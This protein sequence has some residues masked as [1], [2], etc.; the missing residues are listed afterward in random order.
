MPTNASDQERSIGQIVRDL[1]QDFSSLFRSEVALLKLEI[2]DL[3]AKLG[4][5]TALFAGALFC[6]FFGLG[7]LLVTLMLALV[8]LG[9]PAWL[10]ALILTLLLFG[11]AAVLAF[12]GRKKYM[13]IQFIPTQSVATIKGDIESIKSDID[14]V[15]SR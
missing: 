3:A 2:R 11:G 13:A 7:F 5:G 1:T 14:R 8:A 12:L 9:L 10:A 15:R 4:G 6:A